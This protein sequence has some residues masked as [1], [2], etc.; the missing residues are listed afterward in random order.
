MKH[1]NYGNSDKRNEFRHPFHWRVAIVDKS[2]SKNEIYY[3]QT[4]DLSLSGVS[5]LL[6]HNIFFT[7][8]V[9][10]L[11]AIPPIHSGEK[12]T[13][14][15]IQC[16]T[17]YILLDSEY[18]QF[19]LGM[20]FTHFKGEGKDILSNSL[21]KRH[22]PN[23]SKA[24]S[25]SALSALNAT[26]TKSDQT[27]GDSQEKSSESKSDI[28]R[29]VKSSKSEFK[30]DD[31]VLIDAPRDSLNAKHTGKVGSVVEFI[32]DLY[33]VVNINGER[34]RFRSDEIRRCPPHS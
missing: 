21:S 20:S 9:I 4:R 23:N 26:N 16:N 6:D 17:K 32:Q 2:N 15:E 25:T 18:G 29:I 24:T 5:I 27:H 31:P 11:L 7:S 1:A 19:R 22:I 13:I 8:D 10:I 14:L 33:I 3:G 12:E 30:I 28:R 34:I